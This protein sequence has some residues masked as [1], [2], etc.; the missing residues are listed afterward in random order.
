[1]TLTRPL[2]PLALSLLPLA[3]SADAP[4]RVELNRLE[5]VD[6]ACRAYLIGEAPERLDTLVLDLVLFDADGVIRERLAV[7]AGPLRP[8]RPTVS[9]FMVG[10]TPCK[11]VARVLV[12]G[13]LACAAPSGPVPGCLDR[14]EA[15]SRTPAAF[16]N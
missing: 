4:L 15:T 12:N 3:A 11:A 5:T 10:S 9:A 8:G 16:V 1:M 7:E 14:I 2:L 6:G 13:V